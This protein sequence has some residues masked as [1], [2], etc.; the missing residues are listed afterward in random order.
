MSATFAP[1]PLESRTLLSAAVDTPGALTPDGAPD[2]SD[3][4]YEPHA[5][6]RGKTIGEWSAEWWKWAVSFS[7]PDD[8]ITDPAGENAGLKQ[9]GPVT[10]LAGTAGGEATRTFTVR[11]NKPLLVPLLVGELSQ[12]EVGFDKSAAEVRQMASHQA[13]LIDSLHATIDGMPITDLFSYREVSPDFSFIAAEGNPIG[14]PVGDSGVAVADG[15]WLMI[16]P[17]GPGQHTITFGGGVSA[18]GFSVAVTDHI[19]VTPAHRA[20]QASPSADASQELLRSDLA[21]GDR[22]WNAE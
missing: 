13:D 18:F 10:F 21:T 22:P 9:K 12:A 8:P 7:A 15:Y 6:V 5:R 17:L 4:V 19:A 11:G 16:K 14:V 2:Q 1:E 20:S 3:F